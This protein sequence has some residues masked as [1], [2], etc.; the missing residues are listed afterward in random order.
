MGEKLLFNTGS[1]VWKN[2]LLFHPKVLSKETTW[3][4]DAEDIP[5]LVLCAVPPITETLLGTQDLAA[6]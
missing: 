3:F 2:L 4:L 5:Y 1:P 6:L